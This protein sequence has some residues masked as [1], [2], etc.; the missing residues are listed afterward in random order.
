[1]PEALGS[2]PS[3][4]ETGHGDAHLQS[5]FL[6]IRGGKIKSLRSAWAT[7]GPISK[8]KTNKQYAIQNSDHPSLIELSTLSLAV[9]HQSVVCPRARKTFKKRG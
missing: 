2:I 5:Q 1:M 9:P 4:V 8:T 6:G 3:T 7:R